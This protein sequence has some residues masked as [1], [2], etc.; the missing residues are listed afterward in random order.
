MN[1]E[2]I[3]ELVQSCQKKHDLLPLNDLML[4]SKV[5][6]VTLEMDRDTNDY[7]YA[8][9]LNDLIG[10]EFKKEIITDNEWVLSDDGEE[11]YNFL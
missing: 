11:L 1:K 3:I 8:V 2:E 4:L 9:K 10:K 7:Y 6:K 5:A